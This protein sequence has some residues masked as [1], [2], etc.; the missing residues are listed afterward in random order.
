MGGAYLLATRAELGSVLTDA[1]F[2]A[3]TRV[4]LGLPVVTPGPCQ[5]TRATQSGEQAVRGAMM[6]CSG[7]RCM[8][9]KVGGAVL[10]ARSEGCQ[11]LADVCRE[12]G[13]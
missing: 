1:E 4:R 9:C 12:A 2:V 8:S 5:L 10:A 7:A 3:Y 13:F 11:V 6:D